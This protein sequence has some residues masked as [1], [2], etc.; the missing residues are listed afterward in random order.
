MKLSY[1]MI[2]SLPYA[3]KVIE[4][5][6]FVNTEKFSV[7]ELYQKQV[8]ILLSMKNHETNQKVIKKVQQQPNKGIYP[9]VC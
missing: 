7:F 4:R 2:F 3:L 9:N 6:I 8:G 1:S 5:A